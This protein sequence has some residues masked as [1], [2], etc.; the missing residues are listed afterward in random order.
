M[1]AVTLFGLATIFSSQLV[2]ATPIIGIEMNS[3]RGFGRDGHLNKIRKF[4]HGYSHLM[5]PRGWNGTEHS[6]STSLTI[7]MTT[8]RCATHT[9]TNTRDQHTR[10]QHTRGQHT[11]GPHTKDPHSWGHHTGT[12]TRGTHTRGPHTRS[13][14]NSTITSTVPM[15]TAGSGVSTIL[16]PAEPSI[17]D[18]PKSTEPISTVYA[19]ETRTRGSLVYVQSTPTTIGSYGSVSETTGTASDD[20][21]SGIESVATTSMET[22]MEASSIS[23]ESETSSVASLDAT[24]FI[25]NSPTLVSS[26]ATPTFITDYATLATTS[27]SSFAGPVTLYTSVSTPTYI[28]L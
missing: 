3:P 2:D 1:I 25:E 28:Y 18:A 4:D 9:D 27:I 10:G 23:I 11:R 12:H 21:V 5:G 15:E 14:T 7:D 22:P 6:N 16:S 13:H 17:D 20:E 24:P 8:T 19:Y 26:V